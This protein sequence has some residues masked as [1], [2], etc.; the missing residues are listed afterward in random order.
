MASEPNQRAPE[1]KELSLYRG[2][3]EPPKQFEDGFGWKTVAGIFFCGLVMM[4]GSIYLGLMTGGSF[5]AVSSWVTVILFSE[6][7]RRALKSTSKQ[8]LIVLL[9]VSGVMLGGPIGGLVNRAFLVSSDPVR[10]AGMR[11][12][13][14]KWFAPAPDSPAILERNLFHHDWMIPIGLILA[15]MVIGYVKRYS[16]GY[17]FFRITSD[18]EK[19]PFP[20]APISAQGAMALAEESE[21]APS[22]TAGGD[23]DPAAGVTAQSLAKAG[24]KKSGSKWQMFS[25]GA[26]IGVV[27]GLLQVGVPAI[28]GL[29]L[30]KPIFLIPQPWIETTPLTEGLLPATPT[31]ITLDL[32]IVLVGMIIPF[33]AVVGGFVAIVVTVIL[34]PI[35]HSYGILHQ[36]QPGMDTINTS[37]ANGLDFYMSFGI[38]SGLGIAAISIFSTVRDVRVK[39][40][41]LRDKRQVNERR[42]R[43]WDTPKLGRGDFPLWIALLAYIVAGGVTIWL[44]W[45]LLPKSKTL[46]AFLFIFTFVYNPLISYVNARLMGINGQTVGIPLLKETTFLVS[47]VKGIEIWLAPIPIEDYGGMAQ[48]FRINELTGVKFFSLVKADL[49]AIPVVFILSFVFWAFI[50]HSNAIPSDAFPYAQKFWELQAKQAALTYSS[51]FV[52]PGEDPAKKDIRDSQFFRALHPR[53][54]ASGV[55]FTVIG[56]AVLSALGAPVLLV[57][58][59]VRGLGSMPHVM[60]LEIVGALLGRYYFQKKFGTENFLR[61]GPTVLAGYFTGVCLISMATI[62][63][64]LIKQAVS[65]APF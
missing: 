19:L 45:L 65:G 61:M 33:W 26:T 24:K 10:D 7:L 53:I 34:N 35:L 25:L 29:V 11:G 14:P 17:F 13:F 2:L 15:M 58:G 41:E 20:M 59:L 9:H 32:G 39:M 54:I 38:G 28:T 37:F 52:A 23:Q 16:L 31:G 4:P 27:F 48:S 50:W 43:L 1:D 55:A 36:W 60:L 63:M 8:E 18:I 47:G 21:P 42:E 22:P 62:A 30:D 12:S 49:V 64:Q 44:C 3:L 5:G 56:Y 46:L 40:K 57:Y 51:T 6:V